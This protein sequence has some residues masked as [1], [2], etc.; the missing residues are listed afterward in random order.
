MKVLPQKNLNKPGY[1]GLKEVCKTTA[2]LALTTSTL[3]SISA[4]NK[5]PDVVG[6][7]TAATTEL[8]YAGGEMEYIPTYVF[9]DSNDIVEIEYCSVGE[10]DLE[11]ELAD[12]TTLVVETARCNVDIA[13]GITTADI[14]DESEFAKYYSKGSYDYYD[15]ADGS[16]YLV[17][18]DCSYYIISPEDVELV[19]EALPGDLPTSGYV[20]NSD[21]KSVEVDFCCP[22]EEVSYDLITG[23]TL[24]IVS[25]CYYIAH[26]VKLEEID[27]DSEFFAVFRKEDNCFYETTDCSIVIMSKAASAYY[28]DG[29]ELDGDVVAE[30]EK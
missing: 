30:I 17:P 21:N 23:D 1:P 11:V 12:G 22:D 27:D 13:R 16:L 3:V 2:A 25:D 26:N 9:N 10:S 8:D 28:V 7:V 4:C 6:D 29:F 15:S 18:R 20:I 24:Y 19:G 5:G 14:S